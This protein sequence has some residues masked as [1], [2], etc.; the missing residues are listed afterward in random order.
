MPLAYRE[1]EYL[2]ARLLGTANFLEHRDQVRRTLED[3]DG[4]YQRAWAAIEE[5]KRRRYTP[6]AAELSLELT[7]RGPV[8]PPAVRSPN[9]RA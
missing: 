1:I 5:F 4:S 9:G 8:R 2:T 6:V 3:W 7:A